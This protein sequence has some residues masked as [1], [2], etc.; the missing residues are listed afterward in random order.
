MYLKVRYHKLYMVNRLLRATDKPLITALFTKDEN[1]KQHFE[2]EILDGGV[3]D[4]ESSIDGIHQLR[5]QKDLVRHDYTLKHLKK[6]VAVMEQ[7]GAERISL[8][9]TKNGDDFPL[10][11][12]NSSSL[13]KSVPC[14]M[15]LAPRLKNEWDDNFEA[16]TENLLGYAVKG[17]EDDGEETHWRDVYSSEQE[18]VE[19]AKDHNYFTGNNAE[20]TDPYGQKI[21]WRWE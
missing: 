15:I 8:E 18:A 4:A 14:A 3:L 9:T 20:I 2:E 7:A 1:L 13:D 10:I 12:T 19:A 16:N 21:E 6:V 11:M 5:E 17:Y